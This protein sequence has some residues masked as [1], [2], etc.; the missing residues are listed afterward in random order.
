MRF[1]P[2]LLL[3]LLSAPLGAQTPPAL[4]PAAP[5]PPF[6][7]PSGELFRAAAGEPDPVAVWFGGVDTD[8]DGRLT[9]AEFL[10]DGQRQFRTLDSSRNG[11]LEAAEIAAYEAAVLAPLR[12]KAPRAG[13]ALPS[14]NPASPDMRRTA[15]R[16]GLLDIPHPVKAADRDIDSKV[17]AAEWAKTMGDRFTLLD[18]A[19]TGALQLAT[20]PKTPAQLASKGR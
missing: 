7:S 20:L 2:A 11:S 19:A 14:P 8:S 1:P 12:L 4:Q 10:A 18:P 9:R 5:P 16:Y 6:L 13:A 15:G 17:S 3:V